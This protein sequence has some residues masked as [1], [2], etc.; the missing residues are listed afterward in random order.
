MLLMTDEQRDWVRA[1]TQ[2]KCNFLLG[3]SRDC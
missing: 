3:W 2:P 1:V